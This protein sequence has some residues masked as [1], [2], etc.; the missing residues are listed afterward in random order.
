MLVI[1]MHLRNPSRD[2]YFA[3]LFVEL[4]QLFEA[5][6]DALQPLFD[7]SEFP[8]HQSI[9]RTSG[10]LRI[11]DRIPQILLQSID[12]PEFPLQHADQQ[13]L[14]D[15]FLTP[16]V[17]AGNL[18]HVLQPLRVESSLRGN[19]FE[20]DFIELIIKTMIPQRGRTNGREG[21]ILFHK[22]L[23]QVAKPSVGILCRCHC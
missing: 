8:L 17:G 5:S 7:R 4:R 6:G 11:A 18:L 19:R 23:A 16:E 3:D 2:E 1:R 9:N 13:G 15:L 22:P 14:I 21:W 10:Q 12:A 20:A